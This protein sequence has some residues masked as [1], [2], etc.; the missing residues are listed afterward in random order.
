MKDQD[1]SAGDDKC[2][3]DQRDVDEDRAGDQRG[4]EHRHRHAQ[5]HIANRGQRR[6]IAIEECGECETIQLQRGS[7]LDSPPV[8]THPQF[9]AIR[10]DR[11]GKDADTVIS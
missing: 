5:H 11:L 8:K 1:L 6:G 3:D 9:D 7:P 4:R 10:A 2:E